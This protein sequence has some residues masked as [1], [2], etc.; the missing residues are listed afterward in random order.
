MCWFKIAECQNNKKAV[1]ALKV[2]KKDLEGLSWRIL[3]F[4]MV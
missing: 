2:N 1:L 3:Y 4:S